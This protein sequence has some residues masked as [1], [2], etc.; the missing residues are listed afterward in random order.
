MG[1]CFT[2]ADVNE[3]ELYYTDNARAAEG[4]TKVTEVQTLHCKFDDSEVSDDDD[5]GV[6]IRKKSPEEI[7]YAIGRE[8][9][10]CNSRFKNIYSRKI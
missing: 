8:E 9:D 7:E 10:A 1:I 5:V 4:D 6:F 3:F 2:Y